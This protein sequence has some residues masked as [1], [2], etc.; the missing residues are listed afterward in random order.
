MGETSLLKP[1]S[2][3]LNGLDALS[4]HSVNQKKFDLQRILNQGRGCQK[5]FFLW[6]L[7]SKNPLKTQKSCFLFV[8]F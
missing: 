2:K 5:L 3:P 1:K 7:I 6:R 4:L 8:N